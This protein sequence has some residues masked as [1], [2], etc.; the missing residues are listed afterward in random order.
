MAVYATDGGP[1][2]V[3]KIEAYVRAHPEVEA[4]RTRWIRGMGWD[5]TRFAEGRW[6]TA[7]RFPV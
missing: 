3:Q 6:P 5:Q 2:I 1:E 4:D 7:V